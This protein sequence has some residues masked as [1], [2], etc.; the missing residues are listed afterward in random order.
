MLLLLLFVACLLLRAFWVIE[1]PMTS[2][3]RAQ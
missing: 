1:G 2:N 3:D